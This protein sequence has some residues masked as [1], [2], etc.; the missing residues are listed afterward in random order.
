MERRERGTGR[1][2][3][4]EFIRMFGVGGQGVFDLVE[5]VASYLQRDRML[6]IKRHWNIFRKDQIK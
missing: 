2:E 1:G 4:E 3:G 5:Q 6:Q